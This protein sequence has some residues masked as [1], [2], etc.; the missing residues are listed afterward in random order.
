MSLILVKLKQNVV[1]IGQKSLGTQGLIKNSSN[2]AM[3]ATLFQTSFSDQSI[4]VLT[5]FLRTPRKKSTK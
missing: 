3:L 5:I 1:S 4:F 2:K